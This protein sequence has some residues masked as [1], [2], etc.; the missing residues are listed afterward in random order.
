MGL[1]LPSRQRLQQQWYLVGQA[2]KAQRIGGSGRLLG[3]RS[4]NHRKIWKYHES[5]FEISYEY[6]VGITTYRFVNTTL[7]LS[8]GGPGGIRWIWIW[9]VQWA[10]LTTIRTINSIQEVVEESSVIVVG[11]IDWIIGLEKN[12][13]LRVDE[14]EGD[15]EIQI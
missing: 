5:V 4:R 15:L 6:K 10:D 1:R 11:L 12:G 2:S 3:D 9:W 8:L 14:R 7:K 13:S